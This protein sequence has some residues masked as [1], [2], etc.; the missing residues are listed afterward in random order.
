M[1]VTLGVVMDPIGYI[2]PY[3]DSTFA[4]LLAARARGWRVHY[5]EPADL[6]L[7]DG[8]A[9][10]RWQALEVRDDPADWFTLGAGGDVALGDLDII[11]M[12]QDPPITNAYLYVTYLLEMAEAAG[13]LVANRP[14]SVR[15]ANEKLFAARFPQCMVPTL[16]SSDS[17][18]LRAFIREQGDVIVKPLDAMGGAGVFRLAAGGPN[19]GATLEILT[20][21]GALHV[22]AQRYIPEIVHGDKRILMIDGEPVPFALARIPQGDEVRGNLA[23]GGRGEGREL[24]ARDRWIAAQVGPTLK[25]KGL[26]FVGLDVIGDYLTEINVTSPTCIRELDAAYGLDIAG[27]LLDHLAV[28]L[29]GR[30]A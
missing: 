10:G 13:A 27:Q 3:K 11:L 18:R 7:R 5:F 26:I 6:Y 20:A 4:M 22:M 17:E 25:E 1:P 30:R 23:A 29:A 15:D 12:R 24:T 9:R 19:I 2:K 21:N 16:V 14:A 28:R 8:V